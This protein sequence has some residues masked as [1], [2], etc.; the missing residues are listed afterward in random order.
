[1]RGASKWYGRGNN[2]INTRS[3]TYQSAVS[4]LLMPDSTTDMPVILYRHI[5]SFS[6]YMLQIA[7]L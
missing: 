5:P 1:L 3:Y 2:I 7:R 6:T 4:N